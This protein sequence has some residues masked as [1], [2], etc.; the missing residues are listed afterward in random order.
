MA[1]SLLCLKDGFLKLLK[2]ILL[3]RAEFLTSQELIRH[4]HKEKI[5]DTMEGM[6]LT[7][8]HRSIFILCVWLCVGDNLSLV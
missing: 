7:C 3:F 6:F 5:I 1:T 2:P 4:V 8:R